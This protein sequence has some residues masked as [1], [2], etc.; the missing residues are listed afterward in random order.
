VLVKSEPVIEVGLE[1]ALGQ[2]GGYDRGAFVARG[3]HADALGSPRFG[4]AR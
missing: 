4:G 3:G 1:R 2:V